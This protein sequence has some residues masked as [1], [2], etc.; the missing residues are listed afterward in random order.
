[1]EEVIEVVM[2]EVIEVVMEDEERDNEVVEQG[3]ERDY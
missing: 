1:M 2:E 3:S